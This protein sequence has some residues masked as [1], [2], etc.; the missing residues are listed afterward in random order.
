VLSEA[1]F[2]AAAREMQ[3]PRCTFYRLLKK[4]DVNPAHFRQS[5]IGGVS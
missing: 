3:V 1:M 4:H 5:R 2:P